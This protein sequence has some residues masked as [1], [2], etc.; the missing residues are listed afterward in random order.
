M[1]TV[2]PLDAIIRRVPARPRVVP[3]FEKFVMIDCKT[4]KAT[5]SK[6][7]FGEVKSFVIV[8]RNR[9]ENPVEYELPAIE[10]RDLEHERS[11]GLKIKCWV[12]CPPGSEEKVAEALFDLEQSPEDVFERSIRQW[13]DE[14]V[15]DGRAEFIHHYFEQKSELLKKIVTRAR[16][17]MGLEL[18]LRMTLSGE[19]KCFSVVELTADQILVRVKDYH[20]QQH[21]K[22]SCQLEIEPSTKIYANVYRHRQGNLKDVLVAQAR[23][24]FEHNV[25]LEQFYDDLNQPAVIEPFKKVL[26]ERLK[27]DGR[28]VGFLHLSSTSSDS[29]LKQ[30]DFELDVKIKLQEFPEQIT[31]KNHARMKRSNIAVY[32]AK[33]SPK[34][35]VWLTEQLNQIIPDV[36]FY[37]KYIDLLIDFRREDTETGNRSTLK[38]TIRNRLSTEAEKIGYELKYLTTIPNVK[39]LTWLDFFT[40]NVDGKFE[41]N[42]SNSFVKLT[43][44]ITVRL[45]S[46]EDVKVRNRLNRLEDIP[47]LMR[48]KAQDVTSQFLHTVE[49][50]RFYTTF[51]FPN[52]DKY[53]DQKKAIEQELVE[54]I[55]EALQDS[56]AAEVLS[57]VPK[58]VDTEPIIRW[59]ELQEKVCEFAF[60]VTPLRGGEAIPFKCKFQVED[61]AENGWYKFESRKFTIDDIR[62]HLEDDLRAKLKTVSKEELLFKGGR[63]LKALQDEIEKIAVPAIQAIYG[64]R[65]ELS[66]FDRELT[67]IETEMNEELIERNRSAILS[68]KYRRDAAVA[69]DKYLVE[70]KEEEVRILID[71]RLRLGVD[72]PKDE[73]AD[74]EKRVHRE[75]AKLTPDRVPSIESVEQILDPG[76]SEKPLIDVAQYRQLKGKEK[77]SNNSNGQGHRDE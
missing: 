67:E 35:D 64:V 44:P 31:V 36:L 38:R 27:L 26:N 37:E 7:W 8:N 9:G 70:K 52:T 61:I 75:R 55:T 63:H 57:V 50:E 65:I 12:T 11:I 69:S 24:F 23:S 10:V 48:R 18:Q 20:E 33:G 13:V 43:I 49:P 74:I 3:A 25:S 19:E 59:R 45:S 56:F 54:L 53:P 29:A 15:G 34:L 16:A 51:S 39:P 46:L 60:S 22:I 42:I 17:E 47:E 72:G 66:T 71:E 40:I 32:K 6:P 73:I 77:E 30:F 58:V 28:R 4:K 68:A 5:A 14:F 21:L 62:K 2:R 41:T 76:F 1:Q